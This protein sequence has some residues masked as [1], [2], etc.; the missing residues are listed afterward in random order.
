MLQPRGETDFLLE[1]LRTQARGH[2]GME[3]FERD[4]AV[5]TQV[6]REKDR[7]KRAASE[8][9]LNPILAAEYVREVVAYGQ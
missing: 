6:L 5:V 9:A 2:F 7:R 1:S 3:H 8:L 4:G